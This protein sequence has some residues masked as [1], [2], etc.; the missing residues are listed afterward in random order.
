MIYETKDRINFE[1]SQKIFWPLSDLF[2]QAVCDAALITL[3]NK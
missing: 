2:S 3:E 1:I